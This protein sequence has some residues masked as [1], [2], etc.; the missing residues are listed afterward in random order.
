MAKVYSPQF[1]LWIFAVM[2]IAG[3]P[4]RLALG[5]ALLDTLIFTTTFGPLYPGLPLHAVQWLADGLRQVFTAGLAVW[6]VR[7]ELLPD[8]RPGSEARSSHSGRWRL[9]AWRARPSSG[10]GSHGAA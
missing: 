9:S 7:S 8:V 4:V 3:M 2:A 5:F 6:I 10:T 1:S